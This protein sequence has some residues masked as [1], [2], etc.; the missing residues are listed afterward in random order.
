[1]AGEGL[2]DRLIISPAL[3]MWLP[4]ILLLTLGIWWTLKACDIHLVRK[5]QTVPVAA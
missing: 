5:P 2:A 1:V 3:A 4:D